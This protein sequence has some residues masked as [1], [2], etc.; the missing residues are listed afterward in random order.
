MDVYQWRGGDGTKQGGF[1]ERATGTLK[2]SQDIA[3]YYCTNITI[4][5]NCNAVMRIDIH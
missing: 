4:T 3:S 1:Q 5:G 2:V